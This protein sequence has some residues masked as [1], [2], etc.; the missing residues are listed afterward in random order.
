MLTQIN[1]SVTIEINIM[2]FGI[3]LNVYYLIILKWHSN[4][5]W[6]NAIK[7]NQTQIYILFIVVYV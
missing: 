4:E 1:D 2:S 5:Y 7:S 6:N 3:I